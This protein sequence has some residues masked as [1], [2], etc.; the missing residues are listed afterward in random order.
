MGKI[1]NTFDIET[2][3]ENLDHVVAREQALS[4]CL[5]SEQTQL[6]SEMKIQNEA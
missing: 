6:G 4:V 5:F 3:L 1:G 2:V